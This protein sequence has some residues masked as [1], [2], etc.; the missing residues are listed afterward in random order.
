[1]NFNNRTIRVVFVGSILMIAQVVPALA[2]KVTLACSAGP[3]YNTYYYTFD[4]AAKTVADGWDRRTHPIQVTDDYIYWSGIAT[5]IP[6]DRAMYNRNSSQ[7]TLYLRTVAI[8][9]NC[10]NVLI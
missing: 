3:G 8:T 5:E 9:E 2:E 1:M 6:P 7:L 10:G 4:M